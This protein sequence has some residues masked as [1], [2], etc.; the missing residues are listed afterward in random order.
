MGSLCILAIAI[1]NNQNQNQPLLTWCQSVRRPRLRTPVTSLQTPT[2]TSSPPPT[3]TTTLFTSLWFCPIRYTFSP[4]F[5]F[6]RSTR[7]SVFPHMAQGN[8]SNLL[9]TWILVPLPYKL[10]SL[11][12]FPILHCVLYC[13]DCSKSI[14]GLQSKLLNINNF[15]WYFQNILVTCITGGYY[16]CCLLLH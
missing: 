5:S 11:Y 8:L 10:N 1:V 4:S 13:I 3:P 15:R 12:S 16:D 2:I 14:D 9:Y 7:F 6:V